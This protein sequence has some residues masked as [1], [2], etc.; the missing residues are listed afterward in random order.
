MFSILIG[1]NL[2]ILFYM[3][4]SFSLLFLMFSCEFE[5]NWLTVDD[6]YL[7]CQM[8]AKSLKNFSDI[9]LVIKILE[10]DFF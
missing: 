5:S 7:F 8:T 1:I 4:L 9:V 6:A 2:T 10:S 3:F